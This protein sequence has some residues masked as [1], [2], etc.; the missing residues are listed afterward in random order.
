[1]N[2]QNTKKTQKQRRQK[3]IRTKIYGTGEIPRLA[4][5][6]SNRFISA[7]LINDTIGNTL[8]AATTQKLTKGTPLEKAKEIGVE[9]AKLAKEKKISKIVFDRGG[10]IYTGQVQAL[11]DGAR[12]GGL[13]F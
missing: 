13:E 10:Y 3:R 7:Q 12:D 2:L 9:I 1:M 6:R 5:F 11:A 4:V 8:V